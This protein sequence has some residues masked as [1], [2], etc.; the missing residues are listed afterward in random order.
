LIRVKIVSDK[1]VRHALA[2]LSVQNTWWKRFLLRKNL[3]DT[4]PPLQ[5]ADFQSIFARTASAVNL[6]KSSINTNRKSITRFP[7][8]IR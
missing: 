4:D 7:M 1:V 2:Y 5:N 3:A 8:S 6:A